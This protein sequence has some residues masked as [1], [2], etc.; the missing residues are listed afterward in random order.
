MRMVGFAVLAVLALL[1]SLSP[2]MPKPTGPTPATIKGRERY[3][4]LTQINVHNVSTL[5]PAWAS[6]LEEQG[7]ASASRTYRIRTRWWSRA[8]CTYRGHSA[9]SRRSIQRLVN[10][11][12][13][14]QRHAAVTGVLA[15]LRCAA[16]PTRRE[17]RQRPARILFGTEDGE[18]YALD[19]ETGKPVPEFGAQGVLNL[20]T[21]EVMKGFPHMHYG[22][23]SAPLIYQDL[24]I[25]GSH[26]DDET[27][28]KGPAGD[29]RAW[30][31]RTGNL[32]W[33]FHTVPR[34]G[35]TG[36][37]TWTGDHLERCCRG[38]CLVLLHSRHANAAS[39]IC[40]WAP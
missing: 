33:T 25:T 22:L 9:M 14:I 12:G 19:A 10:N 20:K 24:V 30:D 34:P 32:I 29:V 4:P 28:S 18:L 36:H 6:P 16:W 8:G 3:S 27:G 2:R 37:E 15:C 40:R 21:P 7:D 39:S 17:T 5:A 35:E 11:S 23:T 31:I 13:D 1:V 38:G 26:V